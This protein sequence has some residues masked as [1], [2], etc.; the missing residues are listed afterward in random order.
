MLEWEKLWARTEQEW[1][2]NHTILYSRKKSNVRNSIKDEKGKKIIIIQLIQKKK[3]KI[4]ELILNVN[5]FF[6]K[7]ALTVCLLLSSPISLCQHWSKYNLR[8]IEQ[9]VNNE[10]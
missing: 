5:V 2:Q 3:I 6:F 7:F 1:K 10:R 8:H 9:P 4:Y